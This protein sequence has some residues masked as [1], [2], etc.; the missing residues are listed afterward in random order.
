MSGGSFGHIYLASHLD[1][2]IDRHRHLYRMLETLK[3]EHPDS[4]ATRDTE[5]LVAALEALDEAVRIGVA[6]LAPVWRAVEWE[7]SGDTTD[8]QTRE[9]VEAYER[10]DGA[11]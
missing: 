9:A 6:R 4:E 1:E 7:H 10:K 5:Q 8:V 2:I 3:R 11:K